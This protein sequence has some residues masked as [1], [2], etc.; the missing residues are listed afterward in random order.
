[1]PSKPKDEDKSKSDSKEKITSVR[2]RESVMKDINKITGELAAEDGILRSA[3]QVIK[4]LIDNY[5]KK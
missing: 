5:R 1:M 2:V 4:I 3:E